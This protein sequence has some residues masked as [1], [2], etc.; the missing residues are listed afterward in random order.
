MVPLTMCKQ[1]YFVLRTQS[2]RKLLPV[3]IDR[4][5]QLLIEDPF[6]LQQLHISNE[7]ILD[8]YRKQE[9]LQNQHNSSS[10]TSGL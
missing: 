7:E 4:N 9:E 2:Q 1:D 3:S 5:H 6:L 10:S 8:F